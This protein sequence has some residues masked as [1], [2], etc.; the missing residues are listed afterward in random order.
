MPRRQFPGSRQ[1]KAGTLLRRSSCAGVGN[2]KEDIARIAAFRH[3]PCGKMN[4]ALPCG[5]DC[6]FQQ[7][8][9]RFA[10]GA[11]IATIELAQ[12]WRHIPRKA[13]ASIFSSRSYCT[14]SFAQEPLKI[15]GCG[16]AV[17]FLAALLH[18]SLV[19]VRMAK[20]MGHAPGCGQHICGILT[21]CWRQGA[22]LQRRP[23]TQQ[24]IKRSAQSCFTGF[25]LGKSC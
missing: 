19:C 6:A 7:Q 20:H 3:S 18:P 14:V 24:I 12:M 22:L 1:R 11:L 4:S 21:H 16:R 15:K 9:Q 8:I 23:L 10:Q 13:N 5:P 2:S 25:G 17:G